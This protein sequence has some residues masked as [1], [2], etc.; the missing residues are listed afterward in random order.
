MRPIGIKKCLALKKKKKFDFFD[1]ALLRSSSNT[2]RIAKLASRFRK[3]KLIFRHTF[4]RFPIDS[5][6]A[7]NYSQGE[8][9]II[10]VH[11]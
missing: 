7:R 6:G 9:K 10:R 3:Q 2:A 11:I 4:E 8:K 5:N 1:S